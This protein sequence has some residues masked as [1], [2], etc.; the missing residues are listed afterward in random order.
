VAARIA[1]GTLP[2]VAGGNPERPNLCSLASI[3]LEDLRGRALERD[4]R[5]AWIADFAAGRV[6]RL[7]VPVPAATGQSPFAIPRAHTTFS[8]TES[9][10]VHEEHLPGSKPFA[11]DSSQFRLPQPSPTT[12]SCPASVW[13]KGPV[14]A[15]QTLRTT[16][17]NH[18]LEA[19]RHRATPAGRQIALQPV[20]SLTNLG[21]SR[22]AP[23]PSWAVPRSWQAGVR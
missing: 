11:L 4:P 6:A 9:R 17:L 10:P 20:W 15:G 13:P 2:Q 19:A 7:G 12:L 18:Q 23:R 21:V 5:E 3:R 16:F 14:T 22:G 8:E 1:K